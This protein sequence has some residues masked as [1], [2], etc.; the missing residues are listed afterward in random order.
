MPEVLEHSLSASLCR[1]QG[2]VHDPRWGLA[3]RPGV[4]SGAKQH[5]VRPDGQG[6]SLS[7]CKMLAFITDA[8]GQF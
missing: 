5:P 7:F 1:W 8:N 2:E 6:S 4:T 3:R